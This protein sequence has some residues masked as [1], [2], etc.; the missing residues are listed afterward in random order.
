MINKRIITIILIVLLILI[1]VL[2][3]VWLGSK[4][5]MLAENDNVL[6]WTIIG[7]MGSWAGS[8]FGAIALTISL[9]ALWIPQRVKISVTVSV[10]HMLSQIPGVNRVDAYIITVKNIGLRPITVSNVYLNFG[11]KRGDIF[12][13][14]LNV[15]SVLQA[16]T[17]QFPKRL[18]QGESFDYYLLRD[19]LNTALSNTEQ[20]TPHD[21]SLRI[22]VDEVIKGTRY[23]STN[24][25]L[26]TFIGE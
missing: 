23:Y 4:A 25:T 6:R 22:R 9:F 14:M 10:G 24:W 26:G 11:K 7:A 19:K 16:Y 5:I 3:C 21:A 1:I 12:V 8:I 17:P 15:G 20:N 18:D 2:I 13:G